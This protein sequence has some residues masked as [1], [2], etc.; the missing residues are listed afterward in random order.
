MKYSQDIL[1]R[2]LLRMQSID[3]P[4]Y[5]DAT[6]LDMLA[7]LLTRE[8]II[9]YNEVEWQA[10][11]PQVLLGGV[12]KFVQRI[13]PREEVVRVWHSSAI[14]RAKCSQNM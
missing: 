4:G 2:L 13:I 12:E 14:M 8:Q 11:Y 7:Q 9:D 10:F 3:Y 5:K 1:H 6:E